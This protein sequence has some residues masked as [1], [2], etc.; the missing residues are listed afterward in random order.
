MNKIITILLL[1]ILFSCGTGTT[2]STPTGTTPVNVQGNSSYIRIVDKF[3]GHV[4]NI[5]PTEQVICILQDT[6][7]LF[8][9]E[10]Q[11]Q[12]TISPVHH[13]YYLQDTVMNNHIFKIWSLR[14]H[15][16]NQCYNRK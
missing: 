2:V 4:V 3:G 13:F 14:P 15:G 8:I 1:T 12:I 11:P 5:M 10:N 7:Y 16:N 9:P 6:Q